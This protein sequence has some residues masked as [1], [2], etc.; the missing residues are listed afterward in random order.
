[1]KM[2]LGLV[3][4]VL[5]ALMLCAS[6]E[7][8]AGTADLQAERPSPAS[9]EQPE[10]SAALQSQTAIPANVPPEPRTD[11]P[12]PPL[13]ATPPSP[14]RWT[15]TEEDG[16][17]V[18]RAVGE[19][20]AEYPSFVQTGPDLYVYARIPRYG[21]NM[22]GHAVVR[23][24]P[25]TLRAETIFTQWMPLNQNEGYNAFVGNIGILGAM[26]DGRALFLEPE[27]AADGVVFHLSAIGPDGEIERLRQA[28]WQAGTGEK[29]YMH[30]WSRDRK[31]ILLQSEEGNVW[32]FDLAG[33]TDRFHPERFPVIP[34][35]TA[36]Y[37]SLFP[38]PT[39]ERFAFDDESGKLGFYDETG[40]LRGTVE[41]SESEMHPSQKVEWNETGTVAWIANAPTDLRR[42]KAEDI[43]YL[44]IAPARIDFY[45]RDGRPLSSVRAA[46]TES[47]GSVEVAG[48]I[49]ERTAVLKEYRFDSS[50]EPAE[51]DVTFSLL[52]VKTGQ[53]RKYSSPHFLVSSEAKTPGWTMIRTD[54][55]SIRFAK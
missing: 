23:V 28:F 47:L 21:I 46:D 40:K 10:S 20:W 5:L 35:S 38:S 45:D 30:R 31:R 17:L 24:Q 55:T 37:P 29:I 39:L 13:P 15:V 49:D 1:M 4:S 26:D 9:S 50:A 32:I 53:K 44:F 11:N 51:T 6:C 3:P 42:I 36:G 12:E 14:P 16:T 43:D 7:G 34:H 41:L 33:G 52:D 48:W 19:E 27:V 22:Q 2:R 25:E 18:L 8:K 54:A